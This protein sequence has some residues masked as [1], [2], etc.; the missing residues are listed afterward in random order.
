[1]M[2]KKKQILSLSL[3]LTLLVS[4]FA[5]TAL[6]DEEKTVDQLASF[7]VAGAKMSLKAESIDF[8][9]TIAFAPTLTFG[10]TDSATFN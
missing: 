6:A 5:F 9:F 10:M 4:V 2:K 8:T 1:M 7:H 3:I